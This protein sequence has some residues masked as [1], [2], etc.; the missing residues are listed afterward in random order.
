VVARTKQEIVI[1]GRALQWLGEPEK[2]ERPGWLR[3]PGNRAP[4]SKRFSRG[5]VA[6]G[7][8]PRKEEKDGFAIA[9]RC[10]RAFKVSGIAGV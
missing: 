7:R 1:G 8:E 5:Q 3:H 6:T 10:S 2:L 4:R 9:G